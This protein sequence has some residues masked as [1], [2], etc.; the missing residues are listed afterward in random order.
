[1]G[2]GWLQQGAADAAP[3]AAPLFLPLV[4]ALLVFDLLHELLLL[5]LLVLQLL[6]KPDCCRCCCPT[7]TAPAVGQICRCG[8]RNF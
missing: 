2:V 3:A 8:C 5:Q 4:N 6:L 7:A 1:M